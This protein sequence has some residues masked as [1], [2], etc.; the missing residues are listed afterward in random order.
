M[1]LT[2]VIESTIYKKVNWLFLWSIIFIL[3]PIAAYYFVPHTFIPK[4][5]KN[6]F[7][8]NVLAGINTMGLGA[9][10]TY[11]IVD[12][13]YKN[14][15]QEKYEKLRNYI[16]ETLT[17]T[18]NNVLDNFI[19]DLELN[20]TIRNMLLYKIKQG[21]LVLDE[22]FEDIDKGLESKIAKFRPPDYV[23]HFIESNEWN[24][25]KIE[26]I[27]PM[28]F[29]VVENQIHIDYLSKVLLN[30]TNLY[31]LT[32]KGRNLRCIDS[33]TVK[34]NILYLIKNIIDLRDS[35]LSKA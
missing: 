31:E 7:L 23:S 1:N 10:F 17:I 4:C 32:L 24:F 3:V 11:F 5:L 28:F 14:K 19:W 16:I 2:K 34:E 15:I 18:A 26:T 30:I 33:K 20:E 21:K 8:L 6:D 29:N 25:K 27:S 13:H 22:Y 35:L 12:Q 9:L